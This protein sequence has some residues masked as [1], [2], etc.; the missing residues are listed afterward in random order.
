MPTLSTDDSRSSTVN[1]A[2]S[3][4]AAI[5][6][7]ELQRLVDGGHP[8]DLIRQGLA[9]PAPSRTV[10][11]L[12]LPERELNPLESASRKLV[13]D[14]IA[15]VCHVVERTHAIHFDS[16]LQLKPFGSE[17]LGA[18]SLLYV[19]RDGLAADRAMRERLGNGKPLPQDLNVPQPI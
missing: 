2:A 3:A 13:K 18:V 15:A 11:W 19:I 12:S 9:E 6:R 4:S 8:R 1:A 14:A 10:T 16:E 17:P 7:A 5:V